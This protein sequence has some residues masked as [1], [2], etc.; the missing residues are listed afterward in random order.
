[1]AHHSRNQRAL[2]G[3]L[4][5]GA[6]LRLGAPRAGVGHRRAHR[7]P[8]SRHRRP[9]DHADLLNRKP[10]CRPRGPHRHRRAIA[11]AADCG[12]P[13]RKPAPRR[14]GCSRRWGGNTHARVQKELRGSASASS[15][16][17]LHYYRLGALDSLE[18]LA[19]R[20][21]Y[22][23]TGKASA[24]GP[25]TPDAPALVIRRSRPLSVPLP[26]ASLLLAGLGLV[27]IGLRRRRD[28]TR[29]GGNM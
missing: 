1:M 20:L 27:A 16:E 13:H 19:G 8:P 29:R 15:E 21:R 14:I 17:G 12:P 3:I 9:T 22:R 4:S 2:V 7:Q 25:I 23:I 24:I 26:E 11:L 6:G 28:A 18:P 10:R 5:R